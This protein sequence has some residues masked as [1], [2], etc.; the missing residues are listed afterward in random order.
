[1]VS[2]TRTHDLECVE[3]GARFQHWHPLTRTCSFACRRKRV[4]RM[5]IESTRRS[6]E[7]AKAEE[8]QNDCS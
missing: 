1:M 4:T 8:A 3:C 7:A 6:R 5:T 2:T